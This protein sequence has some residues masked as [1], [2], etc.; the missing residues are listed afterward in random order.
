MLFKLYFVSIS[1]TLLSIKTVAQKGYN[2]SLQY[3]KAELIEDLTYLEEFLIKGH[4]G[5]YWYSSKNDFLEAF[6]QIEN[7]LNSNMT[8]LEFLNQV[9]RLNNTIKCVHSDIRPSLEFDR[10][11]KDSVNLIPINIMK[12]DSTYIVYQN[13]SESKALSF[14]TKLISINDILIAEIIAFLLPVIPSDGDN[15]SRKHTSLKRG[16]YRY[17]SYYVNSTS[18]T[19]KIVYENDNG[20]PS[21]IMVP[22]LKKGVFNQKRRLLEET[23]SNYPPISFRILDSSSTA[24][25]TIRSFRND[26]MEKEQIVFKDFITSFFKQLAERKSENLIIDLRNNGGGYSE[27]AAILYTFLSDTSFQYC[28]NQFVTTNKLIEGVD[29]DIPETFHGYPEGIVLEN[30]Q[31]KWPNHSVLGWREPAAL[32]FNGNIYFLINGGCSSTTSELASLARS[33][34]IGTF[35]GEEVGGSYAGNSGGILGWFELPNTK[36]KVRMAMVKYEITESPVKNKQGVIPDFKVFYSIEDIIK[37]ND[38]EMAL[39]LLKIKEQN[40]LNHKQH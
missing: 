10:Y 17:Y 16:F 18:S 2:K 33:N 36:L 9:A 26:L 32:N 4:P 11:W 31:Y 35:I 7:S 13:L 3:E 28:K 29:Y 22:G 37:G 19:F 5:L 34:N 39:A 38:L 21:E 24:I 27:Y 14:G 40:A 12:V 1:L 8:E 23:Q 20:K 6:K 30:G 15:Q 25:L